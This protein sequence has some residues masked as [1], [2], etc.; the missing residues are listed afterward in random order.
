MEWT[1]LEVESCPGRPSLSAS[2][3]FAAVPTGSCL[4]YEFIC[5]IMNHLG[6]PP[7]FSVV[8]Q[9]FL[10]VWWDVETWT[11]ID[12]HARST[13]AEDIRCA[14][15]LAE[16]GNGKIAGWMLL[17]GE[18]WT[19]CDAC[20]HLRGRA[21]RAYHLHNRVPVCHV[22]RAEKAFCTIDLS[23]QPFLQVVVYLTN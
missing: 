12:M 22:R 7:E 5:F 2:L 20:W 11:R 18:T 8:P 3:N 19:Q 10:P 9:E 16:A 15:C 1:F 23:I 17:S 14:G 21:L 6:L 13:L 4:G